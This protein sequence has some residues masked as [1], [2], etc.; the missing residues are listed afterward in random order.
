MTTVVSRN[1]SISYIVILIAVIIMACIWPLKLIRYTETA[2]SDEIMVMESDPI[3]VE[4][5]MTQMFDGIGGELKSVDLY[6][7]N[8]M[9]GQIMTFR[10]YDENHEQIF[11]EFYS[12]PQEFIAPGFVNIPVRYDME[13]GLEYSFIVEGLTTDLYCAYED[14]ET[15]TSPVNYF[16]AYGGAVVPEY[17]LIVRYNYACPLKTWQMLVSL[18]ILLA[19][20]VALCVVMRKM[21]DKEVAIKRVLQIVV[22][23]VLIVLALCIIYVILGKKLFG[24]DTKNNVFITGGLL[25][26]L[27]IAGYKVNFTETAIP[28]N[29]MAEIKKIDVRRIIRVISIATMIWYTYEYMNGLYDVFHYISAGKMAICF[30]FLIMSTFDRKELLNIPNAIWLIAGP[31]AG[32]MYYKP[33]IQENEWD[34]LFRVHGWIIAVGGFV[35]INIVYA[36][37]RAIRKK[38]AFAKPDL[39]FVIPFVVFCIGICAFANGRSWTW[40][41]V[42]LCL[43]LAFRLC[44][45]DDRKTFSEDLARGVVLNFY[46]MVWFSL[47]HRPYYFYQ[48]YRY[49][50]GYHTVTVTAYYLAMIMTAAWM[51]LFRAYQI[52]QKISKIIPQLFTFGMVASY[53]VL[54]MSRTGFLSVGM[55]V[56]F[57]LVATAV[58][59]IPKNRI[60]QSLAF[61]GIMLAGL[62]Y[63]FPVTFSLTDIVPRISN[64][65]ITFDYEVRDFTFY[66][67]MPYASPH[68][69]TIEQFVSEFSRKVFNHDISDKVEWRD[70]F[71]LQ[72]YAAENDTEV[73]AEEEKDVTDMSNGRFDIF[74]SYISVW[75]LT[76]HEEMGAYLPDGELAVHA[77]NSFLQVAHDH[78]IIF[79]IYFV[80]FI[81][82]VLLLSLVRAF[83]TKDDLYRFY[84]PVVMVC[85]CMASMV[86]WIMLP[87]NPFGLVLFLAMMPLF[88][89]ETNNEESN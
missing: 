1:K 15:T 51:R 84:C 17:D 69:M 32:Y 60:K 29:I 54:T 58:F 8:D 41:L 86:E 61:V 76:G 79:G 56:I 65:P 75:N 52:K 80:L 5:N 55:M 83:R 3:S 28:E 24:M 48:Y 6:V 33:L 36:I 53:L 31:I 74:K 34:E 67:G 89:K 68:Y 9:A 19:I 59:Y 49:Y 21:T 4:Y 14:R 70:P 40:Q 37:I 63:M 16:M 12:V 7:V 11:E 45:M 57:A 66:K 2:K 44:I 25:M 13:K 27:A 42:G 64:D 20:C 62:I 71:V 10:L 30:A 88:I 38:K 77:H 26:L 85:F 81:L 87:F 18:V 43:I 46:M 35:I 82:Y 73:S 78:G 39:W 50:M 47:R 72:V 22:N 23:P